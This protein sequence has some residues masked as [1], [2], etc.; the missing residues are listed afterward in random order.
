[1][2]A[3]NNIISSGRRIEMLMYLPPELD[4]FMSDVK[5]EEG[6]AIC[7][8][9]QTSITCLPN[10]ISRCDCN[11]VTLTT[12]EYR[13]INS[14][15]QNCVCNKCLEDLKSEYHSKH[16]FNRP[17]NSI[18]RKYSFLGSMLF[19]S[20]KSLF[21]QTYAPGVGQ[22]G[23]T[24]MH[25][26]SSSFV[27]WASGCT[28][29]HGYQDISNQSLG[30][31]SVGDGSMATGKAQTNAVVSLGD[32][33][34]ATCTFEKPIINGPGFDFAVFE[35]SFDDTFLELAFVEVSSDGHNFFR[36]P[37]HSLT[38]TVV[39]TSSFGSTD[40][41]KIN[42]LAG[43]YRGGY[44]TPFD[45]QDLSG[46]SGLDLNNITHV[47]II[48]VVGSINRAYAS[49]DSYGRKINDP[50]PTAFPQGGF[51]LD[52]VGV[53]HESTVSGIHEEKNAPYVSFWPNP[54]SKGSTIVIKSFDEITK[55]E[56]YDTLGRAVLCI[57]SNEID[58]DELAAG[59]YLLKLSIKSSSVVKR[60]V[61]L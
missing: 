39:Q 43:K 50:W 4:Q 5:K 26:D 51:D 1:M 25:K 6:N 56:L 58:T 2:P 24:A 31:T 20:V 47:K 48:D 17:D 11:K 54:A 52:A 38:D 27:N 12:E 55:A 60:I 16:H 33:G 21:A 10:D 49:F 46:V 8:R 36:F 41:T 22:A 18:F 14:Q 9:C 61:I 28:A 3:F 30:Y 23:T 59:T 44:G 37:S 45:L 15:Y 7:V 57:N 42:N 32:G 19:L 13:Y 29:N 40:P 34:S 35:N 53:I